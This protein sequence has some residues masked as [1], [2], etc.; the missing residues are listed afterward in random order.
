MRADYVS[1]AV[2]LF[3]SVC[4]TIVAGFLA[5]AYLSVGVLFLGIPFLLCAVASVCVG[6]FLVLT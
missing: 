4:L 1:K 3:T 5:G 2:L 6:V